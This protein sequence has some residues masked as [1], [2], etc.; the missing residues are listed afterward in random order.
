MLNISQLN[1]KAIAQ[2]TNKH[3]KKSEDDDR[4]RTFSPEDMLYGLWSRDW[5]KNV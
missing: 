2:P 5:D 1:I 4:R 3:V